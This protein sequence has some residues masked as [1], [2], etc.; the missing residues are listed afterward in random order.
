MSGIYPTLS[1][2][3]EAI[4]QPVLK[5]SPG[6]AAAPAF[7]NY[8]AYAAHAGGLTVDKVINDSLTSQFGAY[9]SPIGLCRYNATDNTTNLGDMFGSPYAANRALRHNSS[10]MSRI[11]LHAMENAGSLQAGANVILINTSAFTGVFDSVARN[12]YT[13]IASGSTTGLVVN[14]VVYWDTLLGKARKFDAVT[15]TWE[16]WAG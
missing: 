3:R 15:K 6:G 1:K 9:G 14:W 10:T 12:G 11:M 5:K 7:A 13:S 2:T 8:A 4:R 16:D